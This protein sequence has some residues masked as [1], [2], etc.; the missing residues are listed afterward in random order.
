MNQAGEKIALLARKCH[1]LSFIFIALS[2]LKTHFHEKK[3]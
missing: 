2:F 3:K 1:N